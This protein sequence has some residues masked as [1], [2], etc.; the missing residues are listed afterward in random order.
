M[1]VPSSQCLIHTSLYALICV[2][3][4]YGIHSDTWHITNG[5]IA[6]VG[7][8]IVLVQVDFVIDG[9]DISTRVRQQRCQCSSACQ[10]A[11]GADVLSLMGAVTGFCGTLTTEDGALYGITAFALVIV[12]N[13]THLYLHVFCY[14]TI[15]VHD[16]LI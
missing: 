3:F 2:A 9:N 10:T 13:T 1:W 7:L 6:I 5:V 12:A 4:V 15:Q 11:W 8:F 16:E 14:R